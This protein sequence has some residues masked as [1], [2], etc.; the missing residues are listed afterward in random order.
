MIRKEGGVS[1]KPFNYLGREPRDHELLE[2]SIVKLFQ[3]AFEIDLK[4]CTEGEWVEKIS[5][6]GGALK[7]W[8]ALI[9]AERL[10][11]VPSTISGSF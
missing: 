8:K 4:T 5:I 6:K 10:Q 9:N 2:A 3:E 11:V 7:Q 1:L